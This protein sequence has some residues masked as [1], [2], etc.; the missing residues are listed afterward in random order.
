MMQA[1]PAEVTVKTHTMPRM[2]TLIELLV[3]VAILAILA[4]LLLP[5]LA[6]A[7]DAAMLTFCSNN[8]RSIYVQAAMY[9]DD[10]DGA[11]PERCGNAGF[12]RYPFRG[13]S[14][15]HPSHPWG[16]GSSIYNNHVKGIGNFLE[17]YCG[18]E[19]RKANGWNNQWF[20][21]GNTIF[22]CPSSPLKFEDGYTASIDYFLA[23]FGAHQ[24]RSAYGWSSY[25]PYP[26]AFPRLY[27]MG[28][29]QDYRMAF[30]VDMHNHGNAGNITASD[31]ATYRYTY[32]TNETYYYVAE[33]GGMIHMPKDFIAV[34]M[35]VN[36]QSSGSWWLGEYPL[37]V[38]QIQYI[39]TSNDEHSGGWWG[40]NPVNV[41]NPADRR[42]FGYP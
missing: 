27:L 13:H 23:G 8:Q 35:G 38:N 20:R 5:L 28:R 34:R 18:Y 36:N 22:H 30:I 4:A 32:D 24:Y 19:M 7:R 9:A 42:H 21:R 11:L 39:G 2:F 1:L 31:G 25:G 40:G 29:Y 26:V 15:D 16:V 14:A 12:S 33:Y 41:S 10:F 6:Q 17:Q 37:G 3:V